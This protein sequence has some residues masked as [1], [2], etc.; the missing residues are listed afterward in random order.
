MS[1]YK[2]TAALVVAADQDGRNRHCYRGDVIRWLNDKQRELFLRHK[3]VE[4]L[5]DHDVDGLRESEAVPDES[6]SA[7]GDESA[8]TAAPVER[9]AQV[10]SKELWV[11]YAVSQ[12]MEFAEADAMSKVDLIARFRD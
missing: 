4:P 7:V 3:L 8:P 12:G 2:V 11:A 5:G 6:A 10:A 1:G 9:P